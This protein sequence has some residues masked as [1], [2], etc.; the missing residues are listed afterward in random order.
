MSNLYYASGYKNKVISLLL[1]NEDF[2]KLINP[3]PSE[4]P[5]IGLMDVLLGGTWVYDGKKYEEQGHV[6]DYNFVTETTAQP[7]TFVFVE[8]DIDAVNH[9]IFMDFYLSI[10]IFTAKELVRI[11]Q[12]TVPSVSQIKD[13][14]YFAG[15]YANRIDVLC[16]I[17][18]RVLNG[19]D[20]IPGIGKVAPAPKDF[21]TEYCPNDNYYGKCLKYHISNINGVDYA[22]EI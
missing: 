19:T 21:F 4:C 2:V 3:T 17:A 15:T 14:G 13:M 6:F 18:D 16:D 9:N 11:T 5:E 1:K 22:C 12:D 20:E 7:K 10:Y 8:T